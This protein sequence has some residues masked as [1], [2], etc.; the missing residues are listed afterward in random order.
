MNADKVVEL[1]KNIVATADFEG[2]LTYTNPAF[3]ELLGYSK[4]ELQHANFIQY[5]HP[6]D[7]QQAN[8]KFKLL[9]AGGETIAFETRFVC[10]NGRIVYISWNSFIDKDEQIIYGIGNDITHRKLAESELSLETQLLETSQSIAKVGGWELDLLTNEL[11]WTTQTYRIHDTS[12]EEFDPNVDDGLQFYLPESR[13]T[14]KEAL[15]QAIATGKGYDLELEL[16]TTK[17]KLIHVRTNCKVTRKNGRSVKLIGAIQ[18]ISEKKRVEKELLESE[19]KLRAM[20]DN[21]LNSILV[22]DD[23]GNYTFTNKAAA[24]LFGYTEE[25]LVKMNV[26]QIRTSTPDNAT[27]LY[28]KYLEKGKE[29]GEFSFTRPDGEQRVAQ[30]HAIRIKADFNLSVLSDV[31][32]NKI[33]E[34]KLRESEEKYRSLF[35]NAGLGIGYFS[36]EGIILSFN[37]VALEALNGVL[38]DFEGKSVYDIFPKDTADLILNRFQ[39]IFTTGEIHS[40]EDFVELPSGDQWFLSTYCEI[41]DSNQDTQ[42][43]QVISQNITEKKLAERALSESEARVSAI[44]NSLPSS[45]CVIDEKGKILQVNEAWNEFA[46]N[47]DHQR[48]PECYADYNYFDV[49]KADFQDM[50]AKMVYHGLQK[51]LNGELN[52][53]EHEYP[54][55]TPDREQWFVMRANLMKT[56]EKKIVI[57]HIDITSRK[58]LEKDQKNLIEQL[59][60]ALTAGNLGLWTL[61]VNSGH[62]D[63]NDKHLEIYG[64]TRE[65]FDHSLDTGLKYI[66]P[67]DAE[68]TKYELSKAYEGEAFYGVEFRII[69]KN[70]EIR[71]LEAAGAPLYNDANELVQIVGMNRDITELKLIEEQLRRDAQLLEASQ[72]TARVGGWELK[73]STDELFWTAETYLIHDTTPEEFQPTTANS[74][75]AF[76][77]PDSRELLKETVK[78]AYKSGQSFELELELNTAKQHKV[79]V[80]TTGQVLFEDNVPVRILGAIQDITE[81]KRREIELLRA[82]ESIEES[83]IRYR[84]LFDNLLDEVHLWKI[85]KNERGDIINWELI[86]ANASAL[87]SWSKKKSQV[88]GKKTNE[89]FSTDAFSQFKPIV[90][91]IFKTGKPLS[92]ES[93][94]KPTDQYL[95][96]SSI[97]LGEYFISTGSDITE[98]RRAEEKLKKSEAK[99]KAMYDNALVGLFRTSLGEGR[100]VEANQASAELFGY[101]SVEAFINE[102]NATN[103]YV[104]PDDREI[105][106]KELKEK[107]F[108]DRIV[109]HSKKK[110]G[111]EIWNEASF[112]ANAEK[113]FVECVAI[114]ITEQKKNEEA[115]IKEKEL[116]QAN[117]EK[118]R[119]L[120]ENAELGTAYFTPE[121]TILSFNAIG[122]KNVGVEPKELEGKS[123]F[124][125]FPKELAETMYNRLQEVIKSSEIT[126]YEDLV[127][128]QNEAKWFLSTFSKIT[129]ADNEVV[130]IQVLSQNITALKKAQEEK[131]ES[132]VKFTR[133]FEIAP[134][135]TA[136]LN[137]KTGERLAV[138]NAYCETFG[139]SK[140]ELLS[141]NIYERTLMMNQKE[142]R[143]V[144]KKAI[145]RGRLDH[146]ALTMFT[147]SGEELKM[148]TNGTKLYPD[149]ND[150]FI[151]SYVDV[152]E[153]ARI[154]EKLK[155]SDRVFNLAPDMF[156]IA[157][158]DGYFKYLNPAWERTLG[159]PTE[160]LLNN[161]WIDFVHPDDQN[162]TEDIKTEIVD[163]KEVMSFENRYI[164]KDGSVKW[165]SWKSQPFIDEQIM[166]GAARDITAL[167]EQEQKLK[168]SEAH[169][170][171]VQQIAKVGSWYYDL[172][173]KTSTWSDELYNIHELDPSEPVPNYED[174]SKWFTQESWEILSEALSKASNEAIPFDLEL[175][176]VRKDQSIGW[177]WAQCEALTNEKGEVYALVGANQDISLKKENMLQLEEAKE[178]AE[179]ADQLKSAFLSNMSHEIRTP[180][181]AI[182]GFSRLLQDDHSSDDFPMYLDQIES[183]SEQLLML[184]DDILNISRIEGKSLEMVYTNVHLHSY[185]QKIFE[186]HQREIHAHHKNQN[187]QLKLNRPKVQ[188]EEG[189]L[190]VD[191]IRLKEVFHNLISNAIKF[192]KNGSVEIGYTCEPHQ[193]TFYVKDEGLGIPED[194]YDHIFERFGQVPGTSELYGGTGLGL[195]ICRGL[196]DKMGG[197]IW[198]ESKVNVGSTFWFTLPRISRAAV[199]ANPAEPPSII[200]TGQPARGVLIADDSAS[201]RLFY[202]TVM[203]KHKAN[204][205]IVKS[206]E[207]AVDYYQQN[208]ENIDLILMDIRM[209]GI[210]GIE[211]MKQIKE[212]NPDIRVIAQT[213]FAMDDELEK[214]IKVGFDDCLTKPIPE[215][216]L[217]R[218]LKG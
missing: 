100:I 44:L 153:E 47:G 10:K 126:T 143:E 64:L 43:I 158:F 191:Q 67:D 46:Q 49:C 154:Q 95:S 152:T 91:E 139:Y 62:L 78:N 120:H 165:L 162:S 3:H 177:I 28:N 180:L 110:D 105:V 54:C 157:G 123:V 117:E 38:E 73:V 12:P 6:E 175:N 34:Q 214:F 18:D 102:F 187:V 125:A 27:E 124:D 29:V 172:E 196:I 130:G 188:T 147:K 167:K 136:I 171:K 178:R 190:E 75:L 114:D 93:Y 185:I 68:H 217:I 111:G 59:N 79:N 208:S 151:A 170:K 9:L 134:N 84:S 55:H 145:D 90:Q 213:A 192:T 173:T 4:A 164:C 25:E 218:L 210:G 209:P 17:G 50:D 39:T 156:C 63:W 138:N 81:L 211:A 118:Y 65:E 141:E 26:G 101:P 23:L 197:K 212:I 182:I 115:L 74:G 174:N 98:Q 108:I 131:R 184:V 42:G 205:F 20:F 103:H 160:E 106:I 7:V 215:D 56:K 82:K 206:G 179:Q 194:Q 202:K 88:V 86:D 99:Y 13:E 15:Q 48:A 113:G 85:I 72:S 83:E 19:E 51:I 77:L 183:N 57:S 16:K 37:S 199:K 92:W 121:G 122:A 150:I 53:F 76:Y 94:F 132:E 70:G 66:H 155:R 40:F 216:D 58:L 41:T 128:V 116:S 30:Y 161:P 104:N 169:L 60:L 207:E 33:T 71:H 195:A 5:V 127:P 181:N 189:M 52:E 129:N 133:A 1:T 204:A 146:F 140:S 96:M 21:S 31:T 109:L 45:V 32:R 80:R 142:L 193:V 200:G 144:T 35:E 22:A 61:D 107:G 149:N 2:N 137:L 11:F 24:D 159:W 89:I 119:L 135:P 201:V 36:T 176:I 186:L 87:K 112:R 203:K 14:L 166:V 148:Y 168:Q 97:P 69:R 163:G 198:V 8:D